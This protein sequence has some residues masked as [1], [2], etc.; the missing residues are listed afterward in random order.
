MIG[1]HANRNSNESDRR[2]Y[3]CHLNEKSIVFQVTLIVNKY[4]RSKVE[5]PHHA[6]LKT[7]NTKIAS[8]NSI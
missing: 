1:K 7:S 2:N 8:M 5:Y 3:P 4:R 6:Q